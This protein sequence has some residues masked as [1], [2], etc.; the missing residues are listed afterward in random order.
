MSYGCFEDRLETLNKKRQ[1]CKNSGDLISEYQSSFGAKISKLADRLEAEINRK[2]NEYRNDADRLK[3][4]YDIRLKEVKE[5]HKEDV[6][7]LE[8]YRFLIPLVGH[9]EQLRTIASTTEDDQNQ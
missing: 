7:L 3:K 5:G 4:Q 8:K 2:K 9:I 6:H 1:D